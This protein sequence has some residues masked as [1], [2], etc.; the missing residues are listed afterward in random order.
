MHAERRTDRRTDMTGLKSVF[1]DSVKRAQC[2]I[3]M[4]FTKDSKFLK[5][6]LSLITE[7]I[8]NKLHGVESFL[9]N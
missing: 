5:R 1:L 7:M 4:A 8:P 2:V 9:R 6:M 3:K